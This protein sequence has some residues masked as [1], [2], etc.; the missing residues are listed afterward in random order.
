MN[1]YN[2]PNELRHYGVLGM[3]WGKRKAARLESKVNRLS[4]RKDYLR[5][6]KNVTS[7]DYINTSKKHYLAKQQLKLQQAKNKND[8]VGET[9]AKYDVKVAKSFAKKGGTSFTAKP[10]LRA[11][12]GKNLT[13]KEL[14]SISITEF[15]VERG[16]DRA[17]KV[18]AAVGPIAVS[19]GARV[20][21]HEL[22]KHRG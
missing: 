14:Q 13:E 7:R 21:I 5:K 8:K 11:I 18:L 4:E 6:T 3:K 1:E 9:V 2:D 15:N 10:M 20:A 19:V 12:Y 22:R 17:K 16:R